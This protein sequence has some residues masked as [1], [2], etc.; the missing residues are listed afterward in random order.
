MNVGGISRGRPTLMKVSCGRM[1]LKQEKEKALHRE[2]TTQGAV[3][4]CEGNCVLVSS[5]VT[6]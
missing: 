4:D 3:S 2:K 1:G 5:G 6:D